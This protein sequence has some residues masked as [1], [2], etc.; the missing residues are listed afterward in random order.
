MSG[1]GKAAFGGS[2]SLLGLLT[3]SLFYSCSVTVDVTPPHAREGWRP[4]IVGTPE[5]AAVVAAMPP[6]EL[7]DEER[8]RIVQDNTR[9]N[10]RLWK[11]AK[12]V[13]GGQHLPNIPQ[14]V[15]DC[16]SWGAANA[17]NYTA[18]VQIARDG[19]PQEFHQAFP[20]YI[21]GTSRVLIGRNSL[22]GD[23]SVGAW[24][25]KAVQ[26]YGVLR[27][28]AANVPTYSGALARKWGN[29]PGPPDEFLEAAKPFTVQTVAPVRSADEVRD[30]I[31]NGYGVSIAS[32]CGFAMHPPVIDGRLINKRSGNWNHQMSIVGYD[33][34]THRE[35]LWYVLNSWGHTAH[36]TPPDDSPPGGFWITRKDVEYIVRQGDS[37]AFSGF[38]GFPAQTLDF[39][40]FGRKRRSDSKLKPAAPLQFDLFPQ[41]EPKRTGA[42]VPRQQQLLTI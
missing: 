4:E 7:R 33:G 2:I 9:A 42:A 36:G 18:A 29:K 39:R 12:L 1:S 31:C 19:A 27:S 6:F 23:G 34:E 14:E 11:W 30:A 10:V 22:R 40:V 38:Q 37:F 35:P 20:P 13:N 15:G 28:D 25:A 32:D 26:Q 8:R 5:H 3:A 24:A 21:Y 41:A 17:I 16:V